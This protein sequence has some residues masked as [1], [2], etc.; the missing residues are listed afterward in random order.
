MDIFSAWLQNSRRTLEDKKR[1]LSDLNPLSSRDSVREFVNDVIAHQA[2]QRFISMG[3]QKFFD[4]SNGYLNTLNAFR[5]TLPEP[6]HHIDP[7]SNADSP[8][9]KEVHLVSTQ[10]KDLL[11]HV[12]ALS[13]RLLSL[14]GQQHVYQDA[15]EKATD[16]AFRRQK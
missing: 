6:L 9:R 15:L 12:N 2:N 13:D 3:A 14:G 1:S 16:A 11:H 4:E 8:I 5:T 10:Y 7:I